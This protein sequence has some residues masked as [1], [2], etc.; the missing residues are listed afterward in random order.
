[1]KYVYKLGPDRKQKTALAGT[2][3]RFV[4]LSFNFHEQTQCK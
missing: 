1:M 3:V 4:A 2:G